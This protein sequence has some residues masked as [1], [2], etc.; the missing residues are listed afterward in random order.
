MKKWILIFSLALFACGGSLFAQKGGGF[1]N[2]AEGGG[3][4][5]FHQV[6]ELNI[7][8]TSVLQVKQSAADNDIIGMKGR[9]VEQLDDDK[10][11]FKSMDSSETIVVE[12]D[13]DVWH[14]LTVIPTDIVILVGEVDKDDGKVKVDV[15]RI[16]KAPAAADKASAKADRAAGAGAEGAPACN[17]GAAHKK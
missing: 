10:Y 4:G 8:P 16:R 2:P 13:E 15:K 1:V 11:L 5:G 14:G 17:C 9:L 3:K 12:I 7:T 6:G